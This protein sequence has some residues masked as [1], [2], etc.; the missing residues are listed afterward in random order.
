M[1]KLFAVA[2]CALLAGCT[3]IGSPRQSVGIDAMD[4]DGQTYVPATGGGY[5]P[6][7]P[8]QRLTTTCTMKG[9]GVQCY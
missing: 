6:P 9:K 7:A 8:E 4:S 1:K 3:A 2:C 5:E